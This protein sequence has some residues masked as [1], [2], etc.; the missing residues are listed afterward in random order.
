MQPQGHVQVLSHV[1]DEE[2]PLQ[3]ALDAPRWR[4][5]ESGELAIEARI[6]DRLSTK[7]ARRGHDVVVR[8]PSTFGGAQIVR[9]DAGTLSG[10][11]E[12]RKDGGVVGY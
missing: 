10:A 7:L 11:T 2:L 12:P 9:N 5:L 3:A 1:L 4:Y 8:S 6:G